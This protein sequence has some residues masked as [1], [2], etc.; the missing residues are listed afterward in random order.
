MADSTTLKTTPLH[1]VHGRMEA[2]MMGFGGFDMPVQY[3]SIIEEHMAVREKAGLFDVSHMGEMLVRGPDALALIQ[4]LIT[5]DARKLVDG[6]ALYTVMC[7]PEGGIIDDLLV[8]RRTED[9]YM[10]VLNAANVER[11]IE[12]IRDHNDAGAGLENMSDDTALLALQGPRSLDIA[13]PFL[14]RDLDNLSFYHFWEATDG[15]FLDCDH[16]L[17]SRTGYTGETGLEL[18]VP[19]DDAA[20]VWDTL[21]EAGADAGLKPAGLGARDTLRLETGLCLHGNDISEQ[22]DPYEAGLSWLV[23]L[24]K[25]AFVGRD[26]LTKIHDQGPSRMLAAFVSAEERAIPRHDHL[27]ESPDGDTIGTVTSG[28][29]SPILDRGIGLGYVPNEPAYTEPGQSL[30]IAGR[31]RTFEAVVETP[32]LHEED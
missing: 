28:T 32:P 15:S 3:S 4:K 1:D 12:W 11:D 17:V 19:A 18:Y 27:I 20:R 9:L 25:G 6:Q 8:Y 30:Q 16:A 31:R 24:D 21:L 29:Q 26:A 23:K 22:T 14:E 5:N 10:L 2:R 13:Q 7:T